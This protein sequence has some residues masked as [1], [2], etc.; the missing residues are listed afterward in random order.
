MHARKSLN[1]L[2]DPFLIKSR[3]LFSI[4]QVD[5]RAAGGRRIYYASLRC[6]GC[7]WLRCCRMWSR[8]VDFAVLVVQEFRVL[9]Q[10][11]LSLLVVRLEC[12]P[13]FLKCLCNKRC[14]K[15]KLH[16]LF[17]CRDTQRPCADGISEF[18]RS[19]KISNFWR[20]PISSQ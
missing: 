13:L 2:E 4:V 11:T 12:F 10:Q 16:C 5:D 20:L 8:H 19:I 9:F 17:A 1:K 15:I 7:E 14:I 18:C 3:S 6:L